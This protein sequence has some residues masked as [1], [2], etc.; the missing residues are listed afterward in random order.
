MYPKKGEENM[1]W[2]GIL[3]Q[4]NPFQQWMQNLMQLGIWFDSVS[5]DD[6]RYPLGRPA[7]TGEGEKGMTRVFVVK[8]E[9]DWE[10]E[11]AEAENPKSVDNPYYAPEHGDP[12]NYADIKFNDEN[13]TIEYFAGSEKFFNMIQQELDEILEG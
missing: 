10:K 13:W 9:K 2:E 4:L 1:S 11:T 3:K 5:F 6:E 7:N 8:D 12:D